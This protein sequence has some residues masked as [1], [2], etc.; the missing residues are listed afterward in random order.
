[1]EYF[2][3]LFSPTDSKDHGI[4]LLV[5]WIGQQQDEEKQLHE[6]NFPCAKFQHAMKII[7]HLFRLSY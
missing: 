1:M 6:K 7:L 4:S 3:L 5:R 2:L